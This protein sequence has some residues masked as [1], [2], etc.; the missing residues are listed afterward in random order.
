MGVR[1]LFG[2]HDDDRI[3]ADVGATPGDL[4][5]RIENDTVG[6]R[7]ALRD[8]GFAWIGLTD[9]LR[10]GFPLGEFLPGHAPY[11]PGI[12]I[13]LVVQALEQAC[14]L[15]APRPPATGQNAAVHA[16]DHVADDVRLHGCPL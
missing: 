4:A 10:V 3:A 16:R 11:E 15:G 8:P 7:V 14:A 12:A 9:V 1:N 5:L 6:G 2:Q 13:E